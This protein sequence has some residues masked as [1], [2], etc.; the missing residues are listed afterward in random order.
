MNN[1][2]LKEEGDNFLRQKNYENA[3]N[4][5]KKILDVEPNNERVLSNLSMIYLFQGKY[6]EVIKI[7]TQILNIF[8][9]FKERIKIKNMNNL[10]EIKVLLRRAK[11]YE[12]KNEMEKAQK[13]VESIEKLSITNPNVLK[14]VKEIK[15]KLK[16]HVVDTY[17]QKAN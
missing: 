3:E 7:C 17:N 13:D 2:K 10:F 12:I 1:E 8:N 16:I 5:Y 9:K 6:D 11:C 14:E 15:D 4:I